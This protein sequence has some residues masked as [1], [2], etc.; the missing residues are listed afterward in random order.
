MKEAQTWLLEDGEVGLPIGK[1]RV[2]ELHDTVV[3]RVGTQD[4]VG[5]IR[6]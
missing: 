4:C 2:G 1:L 5:V 6:F 3:H